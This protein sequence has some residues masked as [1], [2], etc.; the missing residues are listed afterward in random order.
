MRQRLAR[1]ALAAAA[2]ALAG[3]AFASPAQA[4]TAT[5][6]IN[7]GNVPTTAAEFQQD[8]QDVFDFFEN[9]FKE[10]PA[11]K[12]KAD[13]DETLDGWHFILP[14]NSGD[15]FVSLEL[16]FSTPDGDVTAKIEGFNADPFWFGVLGEAGGKS[17]KH[18]YLL[19]EPGWTLV[20]GSAV[21]SGTPAEKA[22]FNLS[23]TCAGIGESPSPRPSDSAT[24]TPGTSETPSPGTSESTQPGETPSPSTSPAGGLPVTGVAWGA[25]VLTAVGLI[26]AGIAL[27]AV[28][29]RRELTEDATS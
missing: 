17:N 7:D 22:K 26:A 3:L 19:T 27:V 10:E 8:C 24:P 20:D 2:A 11:L 25:T 16:K 13:E 6:P 14:D 4:A 15:E 29:R 23:H 5:I 1:V 21:V 9:V 18:A 28:R 12:A